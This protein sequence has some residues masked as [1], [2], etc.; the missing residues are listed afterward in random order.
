M[1]LND[2]MNEPD[3]VPISLK[4]SASY[5]RLYV[6]GNGHLL[7]QR[8]LGA[9]Y[10]PR[11]NAVEVSLTLETLRRLRVLTE[12]SKE[13]FATF[14]TPDI[15]AWARAAAAS[16]RVVNEMHRRLDSGW[17]MN[18]P[19][20]DNTGQHRP[21]L[22]HQKVMAT[23]AATLDGCAFLATMGTMKTRA[24]LEA[25][26]YKFEHDMIDVAVVICKRG[27]MGTWQRENAM[28][29]SGL[30]TRLLI[31]IT[32]P[33]RIQAIEAFDPNEEK[34]IF[35]INYDVTSKMQD[36][37]VALCKR[38]R[39]GLVLDEIHQIKNPKAGWSEAAMTFA[40]HCAWR[41]GITGSPILQGAQDIWSQWYV[42]DL[43][44][45]FGANNV[46]FRREFFDENPYDFKISPKKGA[47]E[48]I[49]LK[50]RK[51]GF[52]YTK[53]ECLDLPPKTYLPPIEV[54]MAKEQVK[55]YKEM[56]A[57]LVAELTE[58]NHVLVYDG[59]EERKVAT[60][61]N[62]LAMILRLTQ[63]TSGF[64][65]TLEHGTHF[66][67]PNPKMQALLELI[68]ENINE[69]QIITWARYRHDH[70]QIMKLGAKWNPVLI[71]GGVS[72]KSRDDIEVGFQSGK[73]RWLVGSPG[74]A[75]ESL[76]LFAA[77]L[78]GYYSQDYKLG[79]RRQSE[80]RAHRAG[81]EMHKKISFVDFLCTLPGGKPTVDHQVS[82]AL[83]QK[84][85]VAEFVEDLKHSMGII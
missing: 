11:R 82:A 74:A 1:P 63:I 45:E 34:Q 73:Y 37:I 70:D 62:Q 65:P 80:D 46:Q 71:R 54:E 64:L 49:A 15:L 72:Q 12:V 3:T 76:N 35:V 81:S 13:E 68:E 47:L 21:P 56:E 9:A 41:L 8:V 23:A 67:E 39:V 32:V 51:R 50:M 85:G 19:W 66:F 57:T 6:H 10:N 26:R 2:I 83:A 59:D 20:D 30:S 44:Q 14:L 18:F 75:G 22:D 40:A 16:E 77:S 31:D 60:A 33:R 43:G 52:R 25:I 58:Y 29:T 36:T 27:G 79:Y 28:W 48:A 42:V 69:Q 78:S 38:Y 4:I 7:A 24:A 55:A 17:R 84:K 53:E 61:A 5:G